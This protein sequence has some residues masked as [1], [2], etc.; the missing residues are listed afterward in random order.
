[1]NKTKLMLAVIWVLVI[2][3]YAVESGYIASASPS[4]F[5]GGVPT[6]VTVRVV[7]TGSSDDMI[8]EWYSCPAGWSITPS[9]WNPYMPANTYYDAKFTV[10]P[11]ITGGTGEIWWQFFDD[12]ILSNDLL[13]EGYQTVSASPS[14]N[15]G[16]GSAYGNTI[17]Q[18]YG[19]AVYCDLADKWGDVKNYNHTGVIAGLDATEVV[20]TFESTGADGDS[21]TE[22]QFIVNFLVGSSGY[23]GAFCSRDYTEGMPFGKRRAIVGTASDLEDEYIQ[24]PELAGNA[25]EPQ[26]GWG[27]IISVPEIQAIRCDGL[28]EYSYEVN[29]VRVWNNSSDIPISWDISRDPDSHNDMP[30]LTVEPD[31]ELSPWAQRGATTSSA[32]GPGY[33][34]P[35]WPDTRMTLP[36]VINN[37]FLEAELLEETDTY[38]DIRLRATDESGIWGFKYWPSTE[39]EVWARNPNRHPVSDTYVHDIRIF[40]EGDL[41]VRAIDHG[42]NWVQS[43]YELTFENQDGDE[44]QDGLP[45]SW[46]EEHFGGATNANPGAI[47]SN[48]VNTVFQA[49]IAGLNPNDP[50]AEF[51]TSIQPR[52]IIQWPC[53]SGR[54]YSVWWT[55][56]LLESFQP[57]ETNIPWTQGSYTNLDAP[58]CSYYKIKV[59]IEE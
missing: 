51:L 44:D 32:T 34:G 1:M 36:A 25:L 5:V 57:L 28:V 9:Y 29:G 13:H 59:Q 22:G 37:P 21:T 48:S 18:E 49:Y 45:D 19:D 7:N 39:G 41:T 4:S 53:I 54:V 10:T 55:T 30:D 8:I 26:S 27:T 14:G 46:E 11:P 33:S 12:D 50:N 2:R 24:Y 3:A 31:D 35:P 23:Y 58:P 15:S 16:S 43:T 20:R 47:C 6:E 17:A 52:Q 38:M 40:S 56:N 42:G